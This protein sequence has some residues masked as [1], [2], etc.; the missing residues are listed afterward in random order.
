MKQGIDE[1]P[2]FQESLPQ[3]RPPVVVCWR[4]ARPQRPCVSGSCPAGWSGLGRTRPWPPPSSPLSS[5]PPG[6][7]HR[8]Y[9]YVWYMNMNVVSK[10]K[11][12]KLVSNIH[13]T[14]YHIHLS[15]GK[16]QYESD[17]SFFLKAVILNQ[18]KDFLLTNT[19]H[20]SIGKTQYKSDTS[21]FLK[22]IILNQGKD[23]FC[24]KTQ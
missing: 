16:I 8:E 6:G 15:I 1:F 9:H 20:L 18:G 17:N 21:F 4:P 24:R 11:K 19:I 23:F 7:Q 2:V 12:K 10:K 3:T 22:A 14:Y 5:W 13:T